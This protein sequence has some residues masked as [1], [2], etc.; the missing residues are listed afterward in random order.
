MV[1]IKANVTDV[2]KKGWDYLQSLKV[3]LIAIFSSYIIFTFGILP[4]VLG[5][6]VGAGYEILI[7]LFAGTGFELP[8]I[9]LDQLYAIFGIFLVTFLGISIVIMWAFVQDWKITILS[10]FAGFGTAYVV[11]ILI[12]PS[13][14][15]AFNLL[16]SPFPS[17]GDLAWFLDLI[18]IDLRYVTY[19]FII[20]VFVY[21]FFTSI[22]LWQM[23]KRYEIKKPI[24]I[25]TDSRKRNKGNK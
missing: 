24:M 14:L 8:T 25:T 21:I 23:M 15:E 12:I 10:V 2:T 19:L 9:T 17:L 20:L 7:D 5:S 1:K 11:L 22:F 16:I 13:V 3:S 4:F 6:A 18:L